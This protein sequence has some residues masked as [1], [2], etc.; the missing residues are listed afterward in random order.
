MKRLTY[1]FIKSQFEKEG[2][3][4]LTK[5]YKDA[6]QKLEY[7]CPNGHKHSII[8]NH[9]Q[10]GH[11]CPYCSNRI[12]K[13]IEE[14]RK[15]FE[16]EGYTLLTEEYK[17][18]KQKLEYIC[19]NGHKHSITWNDWRSGTRCPYCAKCAKKTIEEV[20]E[21]FEK[22]G[23]TLLTK[24]YK[25]N[26]QKLECICPRGH[27]YSI[28]WADWSQ[29]YRCG[30]CRIKYYSKEDLE[31]YSNYRE[32]ICNLSNQIYNK[33]RSY[34]NPN[35]YRRGRYSYHLDHIYSVIDGFENNVPIDIISNPN[36]L[37][38]IPAKENLFKHGKS[39]ISK[40][41]LYHLAI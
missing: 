31:K 3:T 6:F 17:N 39:Y 10:Q 14:I 30:K 2:Y 20:R 34:I 18:N 41:L 15:S 1:D 26:L 25:N 27:R 35:R 28:K 32:A 38:L 22:E 24:I 33:Y 37:K 13:T 8:W 5:E 4:L 23:Y 36:N 29:G 9:W 19:S 11:R 16:S 21:A 12:K 7:V 40:M